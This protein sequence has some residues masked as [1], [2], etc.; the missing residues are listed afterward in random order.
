MSGT[1][2][3]PSS[4]VAGR[5]DQSSTTKEMLLMNK[6]LLI[7]VL[8]GVLMTGCAHHRH[9]YDGKGPNPSLPQVTVVGDDI[10]VDQE[11]LVFRPGMGGLITWTLPA[12]SPYRF[13]ENGIVIEGR[14]VDRVI[15]GEQVS[16]VLDTRPG[17][18]GECKRAKEGLE[19]TCVNKH[20]MPGVYKYTIRLIGGAKPLQRDPPIV[21]M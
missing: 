2:P 17:D 5:H 3:S 7:A 11:I 9:G 13:A 12:N 14:L 4:A 8:F 15:R 20:T 19:F 16:V 1:V 21:N 10:K 6:K 18:I